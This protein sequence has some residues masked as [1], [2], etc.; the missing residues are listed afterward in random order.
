MQTELDISL[1]NLFRIFCPFMIQPAL[2]KTMS[3]HDSHSDQCF[4]ASLLGGKLVLHFEFSTF[5]LLYLVL[6]IE[7]NC[8]DLI[9]C[10]ATA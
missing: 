1:D 4:S 10:Y 5:Y 6:T 8:E 2:C 7:R 3:H 9:N